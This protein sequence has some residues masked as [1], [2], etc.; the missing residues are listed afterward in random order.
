MRIA[1][2]GYRRLARPVLF[3]MG[4]GDAETAHHRALAALAVAG[5]RPAVLGGLRRLLAIP[6]APSTV[7]GLRFANPVGLA[8]GVDKDGVAL[9]AWPALGF[10]FVEAGTVTAH[11]QPGNDRPRLFRLPASNAI[12]NRM[13]FNNDGAAALGDRVRALGGRGSIGVPLGISL[14]KSKVTPLRDAVADYLSS[15]NAVRDVADYIAINVSSPNTPGLR[16]LQDRAPLDELLAALQEATAPEPSRRSKIPVLVKISPDLTDAAIGELLDVCADRGVA[17]IIATNTTLHRN[18]LAASDAR[19][20][21]QAGGLSGA[22]LR[23]R[24][25]QVVQFTCRHTDLP[26]IGVGGI[27][28]P[29]DAMAMLDAG[30][31]L[32]QLYSGFIYQGP[33][34][35]GAIARAAA[36]R[37]PAEGLSDRKDPGGA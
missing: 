34:L 27:G 3:R 9:R 21:E 1:E 2:V 18:G 30:A 11:A 33:A 20:A 15:L 14:G 22:P 12:V 7:F 23:S 5:A 29:D 36:L 32:V 10:G 6:D 24:A 25:L 35:V 8:A 37:A 19:L 4:G 26:V 28:S 16:T 17:G 31:C 13:G